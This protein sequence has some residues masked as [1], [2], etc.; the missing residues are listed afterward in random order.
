MQNWEIS[1]KKTKSFE[2]C[3]LLIQKI[4]IKVFENLKM[5][6]ENVEISDFPGSLFGNILKGKE[7]KAMKQGR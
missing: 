1:L 4:E 2:E 3:G 6:Q 5:K 7:V